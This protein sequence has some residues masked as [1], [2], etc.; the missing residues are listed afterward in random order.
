M[1]AKK[2]TFKKGKTFMQEAKFTHDGKRY[3]W[4]IDKAGFNNVFCYIDFDVVRQVTNEEYRQLCRL[5]DLDN[6]NLI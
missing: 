1:K 5:F 3:F 2:L 4:G 6:Q